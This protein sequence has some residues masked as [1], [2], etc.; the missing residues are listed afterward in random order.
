MATYGQTQS[1]QGT[2]RGGAYEM[3]WEDEYT[4][5]YEDEFESEFENEFEAEDEWGNTLGGVA[6]GIG[7]LFGESEDEYVHEFSH[8][9][10]HEGEAEDEAFFG[11]LAEIASSGV[12]SRALQSLARRAVAGAMKSGTSASGAPANALDTV[13]SILS[14]AELAAE[15]VQE[16]S[17]EYEYETEDELN[18]V[19]KVYLDAMMEH[20]AH[21]A[22]EAETEAEAA[23]FIA[24]LASLAVKTLP[25]A[26]KLAPKV[27]QT[28]AK[29]VPHMAK[30]AHGVAKTLRH[31]PATRPMTRILPTAIKR[32]ATALARHAA[33]G[34]PVTPRHARQTI[35]HHS[36]RII[37]N[38]RQA[39]NIYRRARTLDRKFHQLRP[40]HLGAMAQRHR[41]H[42]GAGGRGHLQHGVHPAHAIAA[43]RRPVSLRPGYGSPRPRGVPQHAH[44]GGHGHAPGNSPVHGHPVH[45]HYGHGGGYH[46]GYSYGPG[47]APG[48]DAPIP[49]YVG[50]WR[51]QCNCGPH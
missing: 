2:C 26:L 38:P 51:C 28:V 34:H 33:A 47:H 24:P 49:G 50:G 23:A 14:E 29:A 41:L 12:P 6:R 3:E 10:A 46:P 39:V 7:G 20:L 48:G 11:R 4:H 9:I 19:R 37:N 27:I 44:Y 42:Q 40:A 32:G 1:E 36:A 13:L 25:K 45:G 43:G 21:A 22:A 30:A 8:E 35:A 15:L 5:E 31:N 18:P 17:Q 16:L